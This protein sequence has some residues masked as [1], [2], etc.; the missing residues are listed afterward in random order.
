MQTKTVPNAE[1]IPAIEKLIEEG[2]EV[3]FKPKGVSMLPFIRGGRDSV[4]LRK[5][6]GLKVGDIA[7]AEISE[8][9]YVL[10]RIETIEDEMI[11]LMGDGN[12][13]GRERCRKEDVI[14]IAVK[15]IK[16]NKEIDC[17]SPRHMRRAE[18][19]KKLLPVRRYLLAIY[20]R[21]IF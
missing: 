18:I 17:Q 6:D 14:A 13:V 1:L 16:E 9:R 15:I 2:Q 20:R 19:W 11:V 8:G 3:I 5:A 7:L 4:L 12:L 10:H 21:I